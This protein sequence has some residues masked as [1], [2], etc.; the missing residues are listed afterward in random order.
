MHVNM[1]K[2]I[3]PDHELPRH[4][5]PHTVAAGFKS[6]SIPPPHTHTNHLGS[7]VPEGHTRMRLLLEAGAN[8]DLPDIH[9]ETPLHKVWTQSVCSHVWD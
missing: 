1:M 5:H 3:A 6:C 8:P 7:W 9:G 2:V 4:H